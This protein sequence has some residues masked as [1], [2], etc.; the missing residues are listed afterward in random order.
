MCPVTVDTRGNVTQLYLICLI[1]LLS[2]RVDVAVYCLRC[3][4]FLRHCSM[5]GCAF[6]INQTR[7]TTT[8]RHCNPRVPYHHCPALSRVRS[9]LPFFS[10]NYQ[11]KMLVF[12]LSISLLSPQLISSYVTNPNLNH[13]TCVGFDNRFK[14]PPQHYSTTFESV[15]FLLLTPNAL[16]LIRVRIKIVVRVNP[17]GW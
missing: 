16:T 2:C 9:Q 4:I 14:S 1:G 12:A 6:P 13:Q 10:F 3:N 7:A 8:Q 11:Y 15:N 17:C 5:C